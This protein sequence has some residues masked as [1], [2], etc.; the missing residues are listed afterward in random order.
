MF[1]GYILAKGYNEAG[2]VVST[3]TTSLHKL[4]AG[5]TK[6][7][8]RLT[9]S[10]NNAKRVE[11]FMIPNKRT[12]GA[13]AI[14]ILNQE[15]NRE[16][17]STLWE[18][19]YDLQNTT[20]QAYEGY[21][22]ARGYD[23]QGNITATTTTNLHKLGAGETKAGN[24][25]TLSK[26]KTTR[27][28]L[29]AI[30]NQKIEG[31][32]GLYILNKDDN[33]EQYS[34]LWEVRYDLQNTTNAIIEGQIVA[35]S[36]NDKGETIHTSTSSVIKL[37]AG[38]IKVGNK[39]THSKSKVSR[40]DLSFKPAS[41]TGNVSVY[42]EEFFTEAISQDNLI[43]FSGEGGSGSTGGERKRATFRY[44]AIE[45]DTTQAVEVKQQPVSEI[46]PVP[47]DVEAKTD[48][49]TL[50]LEKELREPTTLTIQ[51]DPEL[52][53]DVDKYKLAIWKY[54]EDDSVANLTPTQADKNQKVRIASTGR[55]ESVGGKTDSKSG[56]VSTQIT[57]DGTYAVM[58][59]KQSIPDIQGHRYQYEIEVLLAQGIIS[60]YNEKE[61]RPNVGISRAEYSKIIVKAGRIPMGKDVAPFKDVGS[62]HWATRFI[63]A[64]S[65]SKAIT[66][67]TNGNFGP[68]DKIT[69]EQ[70]VAIVQRTGKLNKLNEKQ[71][72][73]RINKLSDGSGIASYARKPVAETLH[74]NM[75]TEVKGNEFKPRAEATRAVIAKMIMGLMI[76]MGHL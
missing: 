9:L 44:G 67:Y 73:A 53:K 43:A 28:E 75:I 18:V 31:P 52:L 10:K 56:S 61:F 36:Y 3:S 5:E 39:L 29:L 27:V 8:N 25:L 11:L 20:Q 35:T 72:S 33:H 46:A 22:L 14:Y 6:I 60:G 55:W 59:S 19:R 34:T 65:K 4:G 69:R 74:A 45:L 63:G 32:A 40:V 68:N 13:Q 66:G 21:I 48:A 38:E 30:P 54:V 37:G 58:H 7:G 12:E 1:E 76:E 41:T 2:D 50:H 47:K 64:A 26:S 62:S 16:Q 42:H 17:Y 49:Y 24:N 15:D 71:V 70:A 23:D 51:V 57:E